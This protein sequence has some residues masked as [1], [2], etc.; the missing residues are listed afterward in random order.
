M[1]GTTCVR[2]CVRAE[3]AL[4]M[5]VGGDSSQIIYNQIRHNLKS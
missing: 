4:Y 3:D 1:R 5:G 2:V